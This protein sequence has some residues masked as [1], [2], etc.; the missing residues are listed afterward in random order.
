MTKRVYLQEQ[1]LKLCESLDDDVPV[2]PFLRNVCDGMV[3]PLSTISKGSYR[4][5]LGAADD[6]QSE[7]VLLD[8]VYRHFLV[9]LFYKQKRIELTEDG[10]GVMCNGIAVIPR[11]LATLVEAI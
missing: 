5:V 1:I 10:R 3:L 6:G 8:D 7:V 2:K 9:A 4:H 11:T